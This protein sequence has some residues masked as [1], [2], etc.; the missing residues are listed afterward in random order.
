MDTTC[1]ELSLGCTIRCPC[2]IKS[3]LSLSCQSRCPCHCCHPRSDI[4]RK[5]AN[6]RW[7]NRANASGV[8]MK[9]STA[10]SIAASAAAAVRRRTTPGGSPSPPAITSHADK[11]GRASLAGA[12]VNIT[13]GGK[14]GTV[15]GP[16]AA[17][18]ESAKEPC[19]EEIEAEFWRIVER[20]DQGHPVE[21][22]YGSD[23]D[24]VK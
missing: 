17:R 24:T 8:P 14:P 5:A 9:P 23:L 22:L 10:A 21:T 20:P 19:V 11:K 1:T 6:T 18:S 15:S 3:H 2:I 16:R 12:A 7:Q 13:S 4:A